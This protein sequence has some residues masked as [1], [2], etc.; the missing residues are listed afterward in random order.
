M[1]KNEEVYGS[2]AIKLNFLS[3]FQRDIIH[4]LQ[5]PQKNDS[6]QIMKSLDSNGK[7]S[8]VNRFNEL[9]H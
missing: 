8:R 7:M 3:R 4:V 2:S 9:I 5:G 6:T 1:W